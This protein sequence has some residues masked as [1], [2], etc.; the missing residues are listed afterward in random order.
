MKVVLGNS[1]AKLSQGLAEFQA[2]A[3]VNG[4]DVMA[5]VLTNLKEEVFDRVFANLQLLSTTNR[6]MACSLRGLLN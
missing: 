2:I 4:R 1:C 5:T 3:R 6:F